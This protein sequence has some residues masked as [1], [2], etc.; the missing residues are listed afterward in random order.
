M[1]SGFWLVLSGRCEDRQPS[2]PRG[3]VQE[4]ALMAFPGVFC[5]FRPALATRV[6]NEKF[7]WAQTGLVSSEV[8]DY[9]AA[10]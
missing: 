5:F 7:P 4:K 9:N 10:D 8:E 3:E 6:R 1:G 2:Q